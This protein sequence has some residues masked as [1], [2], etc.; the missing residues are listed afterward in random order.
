MHSAKA[1]P[2]RGTAVP[3]NRLAEVYGALGRGLAPALLRQDAVAFREDLV[4]VVID[5]RTQ[6]T[7]LGGFVANEFS[8]SD[9]VHLFGWDG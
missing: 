7:G 4:L 8:R 5:H 6:A 1:G 2:E 3:E 9:Q